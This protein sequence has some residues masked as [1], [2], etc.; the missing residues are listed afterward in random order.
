[1]TIEEAIE[2]IFSRLCGAYTRNP[3]VRAPPSAQRF[4][5]IRCA[6]PTRQHPVRI[7]RKWSHEAPRLEGQRRGRWIM[8]LLRRRP[9]LFALSY[10]PRL[11]PPL[12]SEAL[13]C[14]ALWIRLANG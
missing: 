10:L 3:D 12:T 4:R 7:R 6:R 11:P 14:V 13:H 5:S 9:L 8:R 2:L 1:M